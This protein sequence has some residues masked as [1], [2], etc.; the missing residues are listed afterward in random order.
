MNKTKLL[1]GTLGL[2]AASAALANAAYVW[3]SGDIT[4]DAWGTQDK[5]NLTDS[6]SWKENS[7]GPGTT[8]SEMWDEI[9]IKGA[10]GMVSQLEGWDLKL[11]LKSNTQLTVT[12]LVKLQTNTGA[13]KIT[14]DKTSSLTIGNYSGAGNDGGDATVDNQGKLIVGLGHNQ[15]GNGFVFTLGETGSVEIKRKDGDTSSSFTTKV[16]SLAATLSIGAL[17]EYEQETINGQ[18]VITRKLLTLGTGISLDSA[19]YSLTP[20][21]TSGIA[22][23]ESLT[24]VDSKDALNTLGQYYVLT[25][26]SGISV[27]YVIPEPSA[28]GL[29][30]G[31]GAIALAVSRRRRRSR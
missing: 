18:T 3:K 10:Q 24:K 8:S 9:Q 25:G 2:I 6:S 29:L 12:T 31:L 16:K 26:E 19:S 14:I 21:F 22:G 11:T 23:V 28:F 4:N 27:S 7:S 17:T 1:I 15:G 30:A 20:T 13:T 5:W